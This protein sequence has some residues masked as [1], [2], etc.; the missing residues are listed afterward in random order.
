MTPLAESE[1]RAALSELA[2]RLERRRTHARLYIAGGAAMVLAY[3]ADR[4]TRDIDTA[5]L[6]GYEAVMSIAAEMARE[7]GWPSTWLN[8]QATP[9]MPKA[10]QRHG[11][12]VFEHPYLTVI[13]ASPEHMLAMKA[14]AARRT[15]ISDA[16]RLME[17]TGI[18][19][20]DDIAA[21][22]RK[23]FPD[24]DLGRRQLNWLNAVIEESQTGSRAQEQDRS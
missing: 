21:L 2:E 12:E 10:V 24:E 17:I 23:V 14:R 15:D 16:M 13:A 11:R 19:D 20:I 18:A 9:Y 7:R 3:D 22:V 8:E 6:D 1:I 4:A 5:I